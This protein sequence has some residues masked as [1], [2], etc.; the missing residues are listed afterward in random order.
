MAVERFLERSSLLFKM[1]LYNYLLD[2]AIMSEFFMNVWMVL[3]DLA[4]WLLMGLLLAGVLHLFVPDS[5]VVRHLGK[6]GGVSSVFKAVIF[7]VPMPLCSCGV[8]PAALGIKKQGAGN[9][10]ATGFLIST[11]QTGIDS[12]MVS[13]SM[14][15]MPFAL[16]K[17]VTA[18]ITGIVGGIIVQLTDPD[19]EEQSTENN[20]DITKPEKSFKELYEFAI[21][22]LLRMIWRWLLGGIIISAAISTWMPQDLIADSPLGSPFIAMVLMLVISLPL[23]V[24]ATASVP[25]AAALVDAGMPTGAALV[26]LMAGPAS[27][28]TTIGA[29][30]RSL[31]LKDLI[32]YL[33]TI[34][35]GSFGFGYAFDFIVVKSY[36]TIGHC[37]DAH[38][39]VITTISALILVGFIIKF[40]IQEITGLFCSTKESN[41]IMVLKVKGMNCEGCCGKAIRAV[42]QLDGIS[43]VT[44]DV[45]TATITIT[46]ENMDMTAIAEEL[47]KA[48]IMVIEEV[49]STDCCCG[50]G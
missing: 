3:I 32:I 33:T 44:P 29:V 27:N 17:V 31:G 1:K 7:G 39:G 22:D 15:G 6:H 48:G 10:A 35:I 47:A 4:P 20:A 2:E 21:N 40:A 25:I 8:I 18:F 36:V 11:P 38:A 34:I 46:G 30:Y 42:N 26:F 5:F 43:C 45:Q 16:F 49:K 37:G 28:L 24:C 9:G 14:L 41:E 50:C 23:Y 12:I 19:N 13:A